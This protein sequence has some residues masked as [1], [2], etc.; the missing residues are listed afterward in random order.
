VPR[1]L[2]DRDRRA[3]VRQ[4]GHRQPGQPEREHGDRDERQ[5][6]RRDALHG[7]PDRRHRAVEQAALAP[8]RHCAGDQREHHGDGKTGAHQQQRPRQPLGDDL[9][10]RLPERPAR[11]EI[12][13]QHPGQ[14]APQ[15]LEHPVVEAEPLAGG[16]E[17]GLVAVNTSTP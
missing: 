5:H 8:R 15:M 2:A 10:H 1:H 4:P 13:R 14:P 16:S 17:I 11:T 7:V 12:P 9:R 3:S 6:E